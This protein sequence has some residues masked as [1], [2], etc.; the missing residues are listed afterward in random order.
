MKSNSNRSDRRTEWIDEQNESAK[1]IDSSEINRSV[2]NNYLR[3]PRLLIVSSISEEGSKTFI[4]I[5]IFPCVSRKDIDTYTGSNVNRFF[6]TFVL[7]KQNCHFFI[8]SSSM[9]NKNTLYNAIKFFTFLFFLFFFLILLFYI[10]IF[11]SYFW[12]QNT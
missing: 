8:A 5:I 10:F 7:T 1:L 11:F 3:I 9:K 6:P 12:K 2:G 4:I